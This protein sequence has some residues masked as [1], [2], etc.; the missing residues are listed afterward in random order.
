[1]YW[2][3]RWLEQLE[4]ALIVNSQ[5]LC[6]VHDNTT[7][8]CCILYQHCAFSSLTNTSVT[9]THPFIETFR[10]LTTNKRSKA[11]WMTWFHFVD[12]L[13]V[14]LLWLCLCLLAQLSQHY[15][16]LVVVRAL[17]FLLIF[18]S[19]K[20][21]YYFGRTGCFKRYIWQNTKRCTAHNF[22]FVCFSFFRQGR[23]GKKF[24]FPFVAPPPTWQ[25]TTTLKCND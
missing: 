22:S 14:Y 21:N 1:M 19:D 15:T 6:S 3:C 11:N 12:F 4:V 18:L 24:L 13:S 2:K 23:G 20:Q 7:S 16:G 9:Q 8:L 25:L 5:P 17:M 10:G